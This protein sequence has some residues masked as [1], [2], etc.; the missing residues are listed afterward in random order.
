ME[1]PF[2]DGFLSLW[3]GKH[4]CTAFL[5]LPVHAN[6]SFAACVYLR[7]DKR[8]SQDT[9]NRSAVMQW[10]ACLRPNRLSPYKPAQLSVRA[11]A[12]S[13]SCVR[14]RMYIVCSSTVPRN[15]SCPAVQVHVSAGYTSFPTTEARQS[16]PRCRQRCPLCFARMTSLRSIT[17]AVRCA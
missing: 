7:T 13:V 17:S 10:T 14:V 16:S 4:C 6:T 1:A 11:Y 8:S 15:S 3:A 2:V 5:T 9:F 12:P